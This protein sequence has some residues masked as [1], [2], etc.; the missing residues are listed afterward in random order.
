MNF[1]RTLPRRIEW[2]TLFSYVFIVLVELILLRTIPGSPVAN[3]IRYIAFIAVVGLSLL[4]VRQRIIQPIKAMQQA[5]LRIADGNYHERLPT[6]RSIELNALAQAFNQMVATIEASEQRRVELIGDVAHEL[7]TPLSSIQATLE[8]LIDQV[9]EP[10]PDTLFSLQDEVRRLQRLVQQLEALSRA[11]SGNMV[12]KQASLDL[13]TLLQAVCGRLGIQFEDKG[14][15]L[16]VELPA[17]LPPVRGDADRLAQVFIN[18]LGNAL[19]YTPAGG[20]VTVRVRQDQAWVITEVSDTGIGIPPDQLTRIFERFYRVD[21]SRARSSGGHG[22]G[23]TIAKHL[24]QAHGGRI[25][26]T[27][28]G[29]GYGATFTVTL[30]IPP[31]PEFVIKSS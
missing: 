7:R 20:A 18:L 9:L 19:Q 13:R 26:A 31:L 6:Y 21:K 27:S 3:L 16:Q 17:Q 10:E 14:V 25:W 1:L 11:E 2:L 15:A 12:L 5:S 29:L 23:L 24:V 22:I 8:G 28:R 4:L 30:P